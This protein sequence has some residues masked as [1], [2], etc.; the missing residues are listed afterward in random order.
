MVMVKHFKDLVVWEKADELAHRV[1]DL[2]ESFPRRH[3]DVAT[4]LRRAALSVPTNIAEGSAS[5]HTREL[6]QFLNIARRSLR[7]TQYLLLFCLR[8]E[9]ITV[10]QHDTLHENYEQ[11]FRMM[12]ALARSLKTPDP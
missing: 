3:W 4:Q 5:P 1:F 10:T 12:N 11:L 7:E 9:L 8:R 6:L 2:T